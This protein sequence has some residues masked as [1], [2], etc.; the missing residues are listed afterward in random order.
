MNR[1]TTYAEVKIA[2]EAV[3]IHAEMVKLSSDGNWYAK[4]WT[5]SDFKES[6]KTEAELRALVDNMTHE[7]SMQFLNSLLFQAGLR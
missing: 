2:G 6:Q 1:F 5:V 4:A 3:E 7:E